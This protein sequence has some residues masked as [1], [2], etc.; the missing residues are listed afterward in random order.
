MIVDN[1]CF[2]WNEQGADVGRLSEKITLLDGTNQKLRGNNAA[3][4]QELDAVQATIA[5][6][7]NRIEL[8]PP[9]PLQICSR[10][11]RRGASTRSHSPPAKRIRTD[12]VEPNGVVSIGPLAES[13]ETKSRLLD[14]Y[15]G[16]TIPSFQLDAPYDV[17]ADPTYPHHLKVTVS[18]RSVAGALVSAWS[19]NTVVG[20]TNIKM[21][22]MVPTLDQVRVEDNSGSGSSRGNNRNHRDINKYSS[23]GRY[24]GPS[25][26]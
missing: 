6:L 2:M 10:S 8:A 9:P 7:T 17:C 26:R 11:P 13:A 3:M 23:R 12:Y 15:L 4:R 22:E 5:C 25:R 14:I 21:V 18:S 20:Y 24:S 16:T 19:K 1:F